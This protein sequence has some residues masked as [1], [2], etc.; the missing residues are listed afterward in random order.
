M[1]QTLGT[2]AF[3]LMHP[4]LGCCC[5]G[6][7]PQV[8]NSVTRQRFNTKMMMGKWRVAMRIPNVTEDGASVGAACAAEPLTD[9][10]IELIAEPPGVEVGAETLP[11]FSY[12]QHITS[13]NGTLA[14]YTG[15]AHCTSTDHRHFCVVFDGVCSGTER[16]FSVLDY[17]FFDVPDLG[18]HQWRYSFLVLGGE[19]R[20]LGWVLVREMSSV[21]ARANR[22]LIREHLQSLGLAVFDFRETPA[23]RKAVN[24]A[25]CGII[26]GAQCVGDQHIAH[27]DTGV[28]Q[29]D[30]VSTSTAVEIELEPATTRTSLQE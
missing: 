10:V 20:A 4:N 21:G 11:Q 28:W 9:A 18:D 14:S 7:L 30:N 17:G 25:F 26:P 12:Q 19:T 22:D 15:R 16:N 3:W 23:M 24:C 27:S 13:N 1:G 2:P 6:G 8:H 29:N 5:A